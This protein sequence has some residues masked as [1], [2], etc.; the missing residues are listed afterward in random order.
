MLSQLLLSCVPAPPRA[1]IHFTFGMPNSS[2]YATE[3]NIHAPARLI[4]LNAFISRGSESCQLTRRAITSTFRKKKDE[5]TWKADHSILL[6]HRADDLLAH[7]LAIVPRIWLL[8]GDLREISV[9][10]S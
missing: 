7:R 10:L 2:A 6:R 8:F 3:V 4:V 9:Q 5:L 1:Y